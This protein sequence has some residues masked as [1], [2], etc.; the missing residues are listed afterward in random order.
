MTADRAPTRRPDEG[1]T[2]IEMLVTM[3]VV[4]LLGLAITV[5]VTSMTHHTIVT[6][7]RD[8]ATEQAQVTLDRTSRFLRA[9]A[10]EGAG[11]SAFTYAG[12]DHI[13]LYS[14]LAEPTGP[15]LVDLN[16][17]GPPTDGTLVQTVTPADPN[18]DYTYT[19]TPSTG[20]DGSDIV[21]TAGPLFT[22]Y[23]ASGNVLATPMTTVA[24]T[25][26]IARVMV[27]VVDQEPGVS[28]PVTDS[29]LI[30]LRNVEYSSN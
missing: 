24:Q 30:Y 9:A 28:T 5:T 8:Y 13:T 21:T 16:V 23:D 22:F 10:P 19:G 6:K 4:G 2:L 18:S 1:T 14:D 25:A 11:N 20:D 29:T 7:S 15:D 27:S 17:T 3:V 26:Q 12:D